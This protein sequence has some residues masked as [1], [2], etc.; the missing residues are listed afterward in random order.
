M[1]IVISGFEADLEIL[2]RTGA[3]DRSQI[4]TPVVNCSMLASVGTNGLPSEGVVPWTHVPVG[5]AE[6]VGSA[7]F[8]R[9][10]AVRIKP[11]TA[12]TVRGGRVDIC[13]LDVDSEHN[14]LQK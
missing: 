5:D 13:L 7:A 10:P 8:V 3:L 12:R 9:Q 11:N 14:R 4:P 2:I 1:N 6:G